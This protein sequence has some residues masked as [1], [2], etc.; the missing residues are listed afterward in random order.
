MEVKLISL[1]SGNVPSRMNLVWFV[2][3]PRRRL[4]MYLLG[5]VRFSPNVSSSLFFGL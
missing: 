1:I 3:R 4:E 2:S 5:G